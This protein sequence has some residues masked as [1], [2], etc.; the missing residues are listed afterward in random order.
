MITDTIAAIGQSSLRAAAARTDPRSQIVHVR[1][2]SFAMPH[3]TRLTV[4]NS[5]I[6]Q[7]YVCP[8]R[9]WIESMGSND[10]Q[11]RRAM[12]RY[13]EDF[14]IELLAVLPA[15]RVSAK[16]EHFGPLPVLQALR[17]V[18]SF[19]LRHRFESGNLYLLADLA[20]RLEYETV[21]DSD[22]SRRSAAQFL[23]QDADRLDCIENRSM[24]DRICTYLARCEHDV[25]LLLAGADGT[26]RSVN[27]VVLRRKPD[28]EGFRLQLSLDLGRQSGVEIRPACEVEG[29]FAVRGC[30]YR[31]RTRC[32]GPGSVPLGRLG[33]LATV[34]LQPPR[35]FHTEQRRQSFRVVTRKQLS[36]R[37]TVLLPGSSAGTG[38]LAAAEP[39]S[40]E[41]EVVDLGFS[42][43]GLTCA[44]PVPGALRPGVKVRVALLGDEWSD[45]LSLT[46]SVRRVT[47]RPSGS[48]RRVT[49][50]GLE[51]LVERPAD[52][53]ATQQIRQY[54]SEQQRHR[55]RQ[56]SRETA[57]LRG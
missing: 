52:R 8:S 36:A 11:R 40:C 7:L 21:L 3:L 16:L 35:R 25:E 39:R 46:G 43:A 4:A 6:H 44:G 13:L 20:S 33:R 1:E 32:L 42:G 38:H 18:R 9:S 10:E 22:W 50:I 41:A 19:I 24:I 17:G 31:F 49:S 56:R 45:P 55:L 26:I 23:P 37:L 54:V 2:W 29:S 14:Q 27:G 5:P 12:E 57:V 34:D 15:G 53:A 51:F 30:V 28:G 47:E 48:G